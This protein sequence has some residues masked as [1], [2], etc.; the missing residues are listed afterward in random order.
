MNST[1][2]KGAPHPASGTFAF[3]CQLCGTRIG[4]REKHVGRTVKCPDCHSPNVVPPPKAKVQPKRV[5][6]TGDE[7]ALRP[8]ET[9]RTQPQGRR[10]RHDIVDV[11]CSVCSTVMRVKLEHVGKRVRCPDCQTLTLIV[12]PRVE[13]KFEAPDVSDVQLDQAPPPSGDEKKREI[14]ERLMAEAEEY[15]ERKEGEKPT[16]P[17][18]PLRESIYS[19]PFYLKVLPLWLG[20]GMAVLV[21]LS[22]LD[23]I[24]SMM[25]SGGAGSIVSAFIVP[26]L[27]LGVLATIGLAAPH[28]LSVIEFTSE[29]Y[30]DIPYW[31][32]QDL[33]SRGRSVLFWINSLAMATAPSVISLSLIR[34]TGVE[35]PMILA[36]LPTVA[37]LPMILLSMF[38]NDSVFLPYSSTV[39]QNAV[40]MVRQWCVFYL[41]VT[42]G[43]VLIIVLERLTYSFSPAATRIVSVFSICIFAVIFCRLIG[44]MAWLLN[45]R[46]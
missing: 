18:A 38:D 2:G 34:N 45:K 40:P 44:R 30:D 31:P 16:P 23:F 39:F 32:D 25:A 37:L 13:R 41:H 11:N 12:A 28:F 29:G 20:L 21:N 6:A 46:L 33:L 4:V 27:S 15:V 43:A 36:I 22:L 5:T 24:I 17:K 1:T 8:E 3:S 19:F 26:M 14:A 42:A 35:L 7:Y 9:R 10:K